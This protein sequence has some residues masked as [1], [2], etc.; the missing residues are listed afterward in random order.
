MHGDCFLC[1]LW[2]HTKCAN[3]PNDSLKILASKK[4]EGINWTCRSCKS[5][6]L[7]YNKT[8]LKI[9]ERLDK[10]EKK[11]DKVDDIEEEIENLRQDV[12]NIKGTG[13]N[14]SNEE[15]IFAELR[16]RESRK[17]NI[18][19]YDMPEPEGQDG[20][21]RARLDKEHVTD[22]LYQ[23]GI[24]INTYDIKFSTRLGRYDCERTRPLLIG[25]PS[26]NLRET[27]LSYAHRINSLSDPLRNVMISKDLTKKQRDEEKNLKSDA[28]RKNSELSD[29]EKKNFQWQVIGP[30][31]GKRLV[32]VRCQDVPRHTHWSNR[33]RRTDPAPQGGSV[34][35]GS[36]RDRSPRP[37]L[38]RGQGDQ[39]REY[40]DRDAQ[41]PHHHQGERD[42]GPRR[43]RQ[44]YR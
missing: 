27:I 29:D 15:S 2:S 36:H 31:G 28:E 11:I 26:Q 30:K 21:E 16:D 25:I 7:K 43:A 8:T 37:P 20:A 22:L 32:K 33:A 10:I 4:Y 42:W 44:A 3:L 39:R 13:S 12:K 1:E 18:V 5:F 6:A 17:E 40:R 9:N 14:G 19:F 34:R 35:Q 38:E 41:D 23:I 24:D